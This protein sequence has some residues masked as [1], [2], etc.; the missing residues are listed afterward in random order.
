MKSLRDEMKRK[1]VGWGAGEGT[2]AAPL[3]Y[4]QNWER[5]VYKKWVDFNTYTDLGFSG[6]FSG[7][8]IV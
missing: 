6:E 2:F 4:K 7:K 5:D 3:L 1:G 8:K